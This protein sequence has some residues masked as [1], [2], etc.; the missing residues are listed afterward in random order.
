MT[1][2]S[3]ELMVGIPRIDLE[4][5]ILL[6]MVNDFEQA[7]LE[8][9]CEELLQEHLLEITAFAKYQFL[10]EENMLTRRGFAE[11]ALHRQKH[12]QFMDMIFNISLSRKLGLTRFLDVGDRLST[13]IVGHIR[14]DDAKYALFDTSSVFVLKT[15]EA[16]DVEPQRQRD[17]HGSV[18]IL[19]GA[20]LR[21]FDV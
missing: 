1:R 5:Q 19:D 4:H 16:R 13:W 7:R 8:G 6:G 15:D 21:K 9:A 10:H 2:W 12:A 11:L 18:A 3:D 14:E 20:C 17:L